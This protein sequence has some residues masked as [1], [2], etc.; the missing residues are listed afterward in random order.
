MTTYVYFMRMYTIIFVFDNGFNRSSESVTFP[1]KIVI[2]IN[3]YFT[4][5]HL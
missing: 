4:K 2:H 5:H 1:H 3:K